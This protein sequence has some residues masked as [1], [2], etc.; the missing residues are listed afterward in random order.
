MS[1]TVT[2]DNTE[3]AQEN[4]GMFCLHHT[5][6]GRDVCVVHRA[7]VYRQFCPCHMQVKQAKTMPST[8]EAHSLFTLA[9]M[10]LVTMCEVQ[11]RTP[12]AQLAPCDIA[13]EDAEPVMQPGDEVSEDVIIASMDP[14]YGEDAF[15]EYLASRQLLQCRKCKCLPRCAR[16]LIMSCDSDLCAGFCKVP[17][18]T[19]NCDIF[20]CARKQPV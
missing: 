2:L 1:G 12:P 7:N 18:E 17:S 14:V 8:L 20:R 15:G 4:A 19:H 10:I 9:L 3:H 16:C 6:R 13:Q 11:S 5:T